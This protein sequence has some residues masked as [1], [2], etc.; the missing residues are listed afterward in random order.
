MSDMNVGA[1]QAIRQGA[2]IDM[3]ANTL[4]YSTE[5]RKCF[6][7]SQKQLKQ[8]FFWGPVWTRYP[9]VIFRDSERRGSSLMWFTN[10]RRRCLFFK[11]PLESAVSPQLEWAGTAVL[12]LISLPQYLENIVWIFSFFFKFFYLFTIYGVSISVL[13]VDTAMWVFEFIRLV[14]NVIRKSLLSVHLALSFIFTS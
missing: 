2:I 11:C 13:A 10:S 5:D 7:G 1:G 6:D 14:Q 3:I 4:Y 9:F 8:C 12:L